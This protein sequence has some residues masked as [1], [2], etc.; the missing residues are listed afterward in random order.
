MPASTVWNSPK[1]DYQHG[2][3]TDC[4]AENL[5]ALYTLFG[6]SDRKDADNI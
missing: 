4:H 1:G 5:F 6:A 3:Q 2:N